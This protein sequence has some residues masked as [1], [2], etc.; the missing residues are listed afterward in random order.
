LK[1]RCE[2]G[3]VTG[4][5]AG[6][7]FAIAKSLAR[8]G[9]AVVVKGRT[10]AKVSDAVKRIA[11]RHQGK[12]NSQSRAALPRVFRGRA[13]TATPCCSDRR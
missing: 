11:Q 1:L 7:G 13:V 6:I 4:S 5:T 12:R 8:E 10:E 2:R 9:A 3:L